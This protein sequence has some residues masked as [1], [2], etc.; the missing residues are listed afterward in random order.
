MPSGGDYL[1]SGYEGL[2]FSVP[3]TG[4]LPY[5]A[6]YGGLGAGALTGGFW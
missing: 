4:S 6:Y 1:G 3:F 5:E 2:D